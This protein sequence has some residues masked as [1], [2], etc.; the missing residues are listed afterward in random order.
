MSLSLPKKISILSVILLTLIIVIGF[1]AFHQLSSQRSLILEVN[2]TWLPAV[3]KSA[4]ININ[5]AKLRS[6]ELEYILA[7][8][9]SRVAILEDLD[10]ITQNLFIYF[11]VFEPLVQTDQQ[12]KL[13]TELQERW[14]QYQI[15][16]DEFLKLVEQKKNDKAAELLT[17]SFENFNHISVALTGLTD[18]SFMEAV[19]VSEASTAAFKS[20]ELILGITIVLSLL[21]GAILSILMVRDI[22]KNLTVM[23]KS[24]DETSHNLR[25]KSSSLSSSSQ[26]LSSASTESAAS[27][28]ETVAS[29]E[30]L[31]ATVKSNSDKANQASALSD[32]SQSAVATGRERLGE[33]ILS[34]KDVA[35]SSNKI[36][37]IIAVIDDIAFQTNLLALNAAVEA[38]RAGEQGKGFAVVAEAVRGLAQKSAD[39]AREIKALISES[40]SKT[41][42]GVEQA[43]SSDESLKLIV[44]SVERLASLIKEVASDSEQQNA[45]INQVGQAM[46]QIDQA[47]QELSVATQGI[48]ATA[49]DMDRHAEVLTKLVQD[50]QNLSGSQTN[51]KQQ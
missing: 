44:Q 34:M 13:Y 31:T 21:L 26:N 47:T 14:T 50:L 17:S 37:D 20:A 41:E 27:L 18:V 36:Y 3:S 2:E 40:K 29:L 5:I 46:N 51:L 35:D 24:L 8:E 10:S 30:E 49:Q 38:A 6:G 39:S 16:H 28:Q 7:D 12:K 42:K 25:E 1:Y 15:V 22:R 19:K 33:M 43:A 23:G 11:K 48:S 4:E 9:D 45:G 32:E